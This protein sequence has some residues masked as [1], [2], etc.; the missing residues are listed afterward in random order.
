MQGR[1]AAAKALH[2]RLQVQ[3]FVDP[4]LGHERPY[5]GRL[6]YMGPQRRPDYFDVYFDDAEVYNY[7]MAE[8]KAHLQPSHVVLPAGI[9]LPGDDKLGRVGL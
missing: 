7:T 5:W 4:T 6:H 8:A 2:G 9:R 3:N 1:D